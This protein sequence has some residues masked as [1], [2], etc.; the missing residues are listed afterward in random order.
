[1]GATHTST[2]ILKEFEQF[3]KTL[4]LHTKEKEGGWD[5]SVSGLALCHYTTTTESEG[6]M[7]EPS[8]AIAAQGAKQITIGVETNCYRPMNML[9]TSSDIPTFAK[10]CEASKEAP[11]LA[12]LL[13][14]DLSLLPELLTENKFELLQDKGEHRAQQ[15][16]QV[17]APILQ[18]VTRLIKLIETPEDAPFIAPLIQ[19][20]ILYYLLRSVDGARQQLLASQHPQCRQISHALD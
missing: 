2:P 20:E 18:A 19:K 5:T 11:F 16:V 15:V 12:I 8:L 17:T 14:L 3:K 9:L 4:F 13:K 1:M 6:W 10:V 7:Y